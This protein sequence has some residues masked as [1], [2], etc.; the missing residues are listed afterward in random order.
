MD[1]KTIH[2][3]A[4]KLF[5][6]LRLRAFPLGI[7]MIKSEAEI[8][9]KSMR[10][11]RDLGKHLDLCQGFA[12]A[13]WEGKTIAMMKEDMWCFEPAVG[14][15]L[16]KPSQE[17]LAGDNRYPWSIAKREDAKKWIAKSPRFKFSKY[18][19]ILFAPLQ[20][21][22]FEPDVFLLYCNP[23]Q[24]THISITKNC[25]DGEDLHSV[26]SGHSA[27]VYSVVPVIKEGKC[28]LTSPCRGERHMARTKDNEIIFSGPIE[29][30]GSYIEGFDYLKEHGWGYPG[31]LELS[32]EPEFPDN[33]K[34]IGKNMGMDY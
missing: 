32:L 9:E 19:G 17:Y 5:E 24:L 11:L 21:C 1:L 22:N 27:C 29:K 18:K 26:L 31:P 2:H 28:R 20:E 16:V 13:R 33:Y 23:S 25:I 10:P 12:M 15:G 6:T 8:P 3:Y 7:K 4:K 34:E 14:Y 30:L